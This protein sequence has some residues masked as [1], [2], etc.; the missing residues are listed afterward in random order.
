MEIH[1]FLNL[2]KEA[3]GRIRQQRKKKKTSGKEI[4][5]SL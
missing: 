4:R 2:R 3:K 1:T 5:K